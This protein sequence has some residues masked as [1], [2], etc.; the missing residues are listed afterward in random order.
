MKRSRF[1]EEQIIGHCQIKRSEAL[2]LTQSYYVLSKV[3]YIAWQT[4]KHLF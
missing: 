1:S 2:W 4:A 3:L